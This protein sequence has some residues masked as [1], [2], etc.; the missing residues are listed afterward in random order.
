MNKIAQNSV[1]IPIRDD[2]SVESV[3]CITAQS[4]IRD[5]ISVEPVYLPTTSRTDRHATFRAQHPVPN[6]TT[7]R[8][9]YYPISHRNPVPSG[10]LSQH[11]QYLQYLQHL[12]HFIVNLTSATRE[13]CTL[14]RVPCTLHRSPKKK[15]VIIK[16][17]VEFRCMHA[18][19]GHKAS[20][21]CSPLCVHHEIHYVQDKRNFKEEPRG[22][23]RQTKAHKGTQ[24]HP[25]RHPNKA[26]KAPT[27]LN[28]LK[29][30]KVL[31][32]LEIHNK[33]TT[34]KNNLINLDNL[35]KI[36]VNKP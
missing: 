17:D 23:Q 7:A 16:Y 30:L 19:N 28:V 20:N 9:R 14:N 27:V 6:R 21:P 4:P 8:G 26:P 1:Q 32:V 29:V 2:I 36:K 18:E 5:G 13:P 11:L 31:K 34:K 3:I 33:T 22:T 10:P 25:K 35:V 24:R 15:L 12:Q